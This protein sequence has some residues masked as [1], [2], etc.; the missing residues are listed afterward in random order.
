MQE[1]FDKDKLIQNKYD[2]KKKIRLN[3]LERKKTFKDLEQFDEKELEE[4]MLNKFKNYED[5]I[6]LENKR[7]IEK[8]KITENP[9]K[10]IL[11]IIYII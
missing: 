1:N 11:L 10:F 5:F 3:N 9:G 7:F 6:N 4:L 8:E 2:E